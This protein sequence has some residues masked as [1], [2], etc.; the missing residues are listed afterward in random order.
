MSVAAV[1]LLPN[2]GRAKILRT[3]WQT[4]LSTSGRPTPPHPKFLLE[5][6]LPVRTPSAPATPSPSFSGGGG[7]CRAVSA[8]SGK[9]RV[10]QD[11]FYTT[12]GL[13]AGKRHTKE[14]EKRA[15][16]S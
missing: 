13:V 14:A 11:D 6:V 7:K 5:M 3:P 10:N 1:S 16:T 4:G 2:G 8:R 12:L 15:K 9:P